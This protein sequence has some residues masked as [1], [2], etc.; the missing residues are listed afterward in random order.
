MTNEDAFSF[1][2]VRI[3]LDI[4][5]GDKAGLV[6]R[7]KDLQGRMRRV[8]RPDRISVVREGM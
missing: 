6:A 4:N 1:R 7:V 8:K 5:P 2:H 3:T